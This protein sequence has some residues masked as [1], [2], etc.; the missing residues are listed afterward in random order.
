M[1]AHDNKGLTDAE[2]AQLRGSLRA[3]M[4]EHPPR[5]PFFMLALDRIEEAL[6]RASR[7]FSLGRARYAFSAALL[8]LLVGGGTSYAAESA[9]PGEALYPIKIGINE[10][11]AATLAVSAEEHAYFDA[12]LAERRMEEAEQLAASGKLSPRESAQIELGLHLATANFNMHVAEIATSSESGAATAANAQSELEATFA[13]HA[14]VLATIGTAMPEAASSVASLE[15]VVHGHMNAA[16]DARVKLD[17]QVAASS[18]IPLSEAA[19]ASRVSAVEAAEL[20][21]ELVPQ[22][23]ANLGASSS[24]AVAKRVSSVERSVAA[25]EEHLNQGSY[26]K[27]IGA[28]RTAMRTAE[29]TRVAVNATEQLQG[30]MPMLGF[31]SPSIS[32]GS[33][34]DVSIGATTTNAATGTS[35]V[36]DSE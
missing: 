19:E 26:G 5:A 14:Q 34:Y 35:E 22:A 25:G 8:I 28:F 23:A 30:V 7:F 9:L 4:E 12:Q 3:F 33:G 29:E 17:D 31:S 16:R 20:I 6:D 1:R 10:K 13:A 32:I 15:A 18:S 2:R 24:A 11:I 36:D 27:A 21:Q